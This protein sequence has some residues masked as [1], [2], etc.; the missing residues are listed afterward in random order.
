VLVSIKPGFWI[1][2]SGVAEGEP[3]QR[4]AGVLYG[5]A[6]ATRYEALQVAK[7]ALELLVG[8]ALNL[9]MHYYPPILRV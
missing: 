9:A 3:G 2:H 5:Q 8:V 4:S 1:V 6:F 7:E